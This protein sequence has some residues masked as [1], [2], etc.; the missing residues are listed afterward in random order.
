VSKVALV[1]GGVRRLG[2]YI[3]Y[4]LADEGYDLAIIY[5]TS[6]KDEI[7]KTSSFLGSKNVRFKLYQCDIRN[8]GN[9]K[10]V[11]DEAGKEFGKIDLLVNN[12]GVIQKIA[13]EEITPQQFDD[14]MNINVRASLF[15]VQYSL[16]YLKRSS[17]PLVINIASL[18]GVMNWNGY[19]PYG[20]SKAAEIKLTQ[21]LA[22]TLA[23]KIRVNAIAPG[24]IVIEGEEKNT[25][26]KTS[27]DKIPLKSYGKPE[28]IIEAVR[29][30][31]NAK[32]VTGQVISV[33]GGRILG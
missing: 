8:L 2:R 28:D 9:L 21:M 25:P 18:G 6:S 27:I 14:T 4:F 16:E 29:Y 15:T 23:P 12:A 17:N 26:E 3:S 11:I 10:H 32:Y 1:T 7:D 31:I 5:N 20:T 33:E 22:K 30:L 19:I 13:F 24:T